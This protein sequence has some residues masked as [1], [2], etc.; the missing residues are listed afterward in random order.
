MGRRIIFDRNGIFCCK[1]MDSMGRIIS[2]KMAKKLIESGRYEVIRYGQKISR[3]W[4]IAG[5]Y[6]LLE[7]LYGKNKEVV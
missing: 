3:D 7:S 1:T 6:T 4:A 5:N 2:R